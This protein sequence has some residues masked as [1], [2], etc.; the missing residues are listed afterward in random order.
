[1]P[2]PRKS[3]TRKFYK[4]SKPK[5]VAKG[6]KR[7]ASTLKFC[8]TKFA[9]DPEDIPQGQTVGVVKSLYQMVDERLQLDGRGKVVRELTKLFGVSISIVDRAIAEVKAGW[10]E[11]M[12]S[13]RAERINLALRRL[14]YI[15]KR[16][17]KKDDL[18]A[19]VQAITTAAK[20]TGDTAPD[21]H[22]LV[23]ANKT[24]AQIQAEADELR[25]LADVEKD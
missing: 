9:N 3:H 20:F 5:T 23:G 22:V 14:D 21:V 17:L 13:T 10:A 15:Y 19:G 1:M 12:E 8:H 25:R 2:K 6:K 7:L 4:G 16:A 18:Y 24:A 11:H